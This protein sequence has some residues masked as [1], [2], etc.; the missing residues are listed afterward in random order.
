M[1]AAKAFLLILLAA[2][3]SRRRAGVGVSARAVRRVG[4]M[5]DGV[6]TPVGALGK[7][8]LSAPV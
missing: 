8:R 6:A 3:T 5:V 1:K 2:T 4:M 7:H